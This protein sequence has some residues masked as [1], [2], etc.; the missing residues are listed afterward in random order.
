MQPS[1]TL[2]SSAPVVE[3]TEGFK[4]RIFRKWFLEVGVLGNDWL[5][6]DAPLLHKV[7]A[8]HQVQSSSGWQHHTWT[9]TALRRDFVV[10]I[11]W[12]V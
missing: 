11:G 3:L 10:G 7:S 2:C 8:N 5:Y 12:K 4:M 1:L 6:D 9:V